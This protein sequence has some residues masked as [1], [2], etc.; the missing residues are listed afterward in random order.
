L[1]WHR[2]STPPAGADC[3]A[4]GA[5]EWVRV[6]FGRRPWSSTW[7]P[8]GPPGGPGCA[9]VERAKRCGNS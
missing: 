2:P 1:A 4:V 3:A 8:D 9:G 7:S 6:R 5:S